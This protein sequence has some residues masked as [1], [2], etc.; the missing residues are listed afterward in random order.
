MSADFCNTLSGTCLICGCLAEVSPKS[1]NGLAV[2][3]DR[4]GKFDLSDSAAEVLDAYAGPVD[5]HRLSE[6]VIDV[7][8]MADC[9]R[10]LIDSVT[11]SSLIAFATS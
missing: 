2:Q 4:C 6:V 9:E 10:P 3:C 7:C 5:R 1:E 11:A 8:M